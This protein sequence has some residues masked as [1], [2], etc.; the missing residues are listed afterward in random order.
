MKLDFHVNLQFA[1]KV[2]Y[3]A[4]YIHRGYVLTDTADN[5]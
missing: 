2:Q 1:H 5:I 4:F 3:W